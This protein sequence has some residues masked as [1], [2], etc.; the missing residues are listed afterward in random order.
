MSSGGLEPSLHV[1][2]S[3]SGE[4][5]LL[6]HGFGGSARNFGPQRR[7]LRGRYRAILYDARGHARSG[8]P[9]AARD[10]TLECFVSDLGRVLDQAGA[11]RAVV[12]GLTSSTLIT[13]VVVP[14]IYLLF[15]RGKK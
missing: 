11:R 5:V 6:A 4:N 7:A 15:H 14:I 3:G 8:A 1:E 10:Y 13:L 12:G 9:E 2:V